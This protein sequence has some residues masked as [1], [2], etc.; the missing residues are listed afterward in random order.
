MFLLKGFVESKGKLRFYFG[1]DGGEREMLREISPPN[2]FV[3]SER[4]ERK[5]KKEKKKGYVCNGVHI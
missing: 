5:E 4:K 1:R 3:R 2:Y